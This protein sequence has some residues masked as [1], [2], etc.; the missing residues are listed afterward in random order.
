MLDPGASLGQAYTRF[1]HPRL[2]LKSPPY[3]NSIFDYLLVH[4]QEGFYSLRINDRIHDN[5]FDYTMDVV[6]AK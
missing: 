6:Q 5:S 4:I 2:F 1:H 3:P